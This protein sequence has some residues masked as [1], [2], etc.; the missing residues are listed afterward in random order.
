MLALTLA[1]FF[2]TATPQSELAALEQAAAAQPTDVQAQ[3]RLALAYESAGRRLDAVT[4]W[5]KVTDLAP[6]VP[7][8][9]YALGQ[10]YNAVAQEAAASFD[11]GAENAPWRQLLTADGLV[12]TGH[13]TDAF[14]IYRSVLDRLPSMVSIHDAVARIYDSTGHQEWAARER[15]RGVLPVDACKQRAPLCEFRAGR[16]ATALTAALAGTDPESR[17]WRARAA[18]ELARA[19]FQQLDRLPDSAERHALRATLAREED[20]NQDAVKELTAAL[21]LVP[22]NPV[23]TFELALAWYAARNFEQALH[24]V[25]P[26]REARPDD[27]RVAKFAGNALLELRR[28]EEALPLLQ[29]ATAADPRDASARLALGRAQLQRGDFA[30][31]I[32]LLEPLLGTDEDGSLHVQL[33]RAYTGVDQREK[34]AALLA[35][36]QELR[37][38][39]EERA[40]AAA[41][42]TIA[43]P[44]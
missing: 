17:Y 23:L 19:A 39:A 20:R 15:T 6:A 18:G 44:R 14:A 9:W 7:A 41:R 3:R 33:A 35:R 32:P 30:A 25:A 42:R 26:L 34:A 27:L 22:G 24:T 10:A 28:P 40:A 4:A 37:R 1:L 29:R 21:A 2:T 16:Y 11:E 36:S 12:R 13:F 43:P 31:A 38:A 8:A 5:R